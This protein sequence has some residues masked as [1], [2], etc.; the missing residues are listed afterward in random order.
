M[1]KVYILKVG[2]TYPATAKRFGDFDR[3]TADALGMPDAGICVLDV[4]RGA[5]LP[6]AEGCAGVVITGSH[7]MVTDNPPWSIR[8]EKWLPSLLTSRVPVFGIC[9]GHQLLARAAGGRV[10]FHPQGEEI[11]T[12][13]VRLHPAGAE[14]V[15][16]RGLPPSFSVH[17]AHAQAVLRLPPD[18]VALAFNNHNCHQAF[19]L[20]DCAW[21]VQF[22]PEYTAGI[23]RSYVEEQSGELRQAGLDVPGLLGSILETPV[24]ARILRNFAGFVETGLRGVP[25]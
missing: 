13:P 2:T 25:D 19:R 15:L 17:A 3:W 5:G 12:V 11:G 9:Y 1:R 22:H 16:F 23:M 14:D 4:E 24:A 20:G 18:A 8:V 21:G 10:G 7:S 6:A